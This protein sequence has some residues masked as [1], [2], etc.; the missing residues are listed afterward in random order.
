[1][2]KFISMALTTAMLAAVNSGY[3]ATK[4]GVFSQNARDVAVKEITR[5]LEEKGMEAGTFTGKDVSAG[6]IYDYDV[7]FFG[8]GWSGY[9]WL[10]LQGRMHLVEFV[11]KRGGGVI[12]SMFRCGVAARSSIRPIFPEIAWAYNKSNGPGIIIADKNHPIAQGL[13]EKFMTPFNDH[14][15]MRLGPDGEVVARDS[16]DDVAIACGQVGKGRVVFIGPWIGIDGDGKEI[17]PI[18][19]NDEKLLLNSIGWITAKS[20][21]EAGGDNVISEEVRLKVL[22]RE[23]TWDW[24]H[25]ERGFDSKPGILTAQMFEEQASL[26]DLL[27]RI[28]G[29]MPYAAGDLLKSSMKLEE[30]VAALTNRLDVVY[31]LSKREKKT[32]IN[33]MGAAELEKTPEWKGRFI[34]TNVVESCRKEAEELEQIIGPLKTKAAKARLE[35]ER[36]EDVSKVP[37]LI[38]QL[39][40]EDRPSRAEAALELG[41][42]GDRRAISALIAVLKDG[43]YPLRR[44]AIYALSWM[45]AKEAVPEL[46]KAGVDAK[47]T[48]TK[49][50]IVQALGMIGDEKAEDFLIGKLSDK[51][52]HILQNAILALGWLKSKKAIPTLIKKLEDENIT[53][54]ERACVVRALGHIGNESVI[55][56]L[57]SAAKKF[58]EKLP[59]TG[60]IAYYDYIPMQMLCELATGEIK[61][62]GKSEKGISQQDFLREKENFYWLTKKYNAFLGRLFH[63]GD[64][65]HSQ[66]SQI[67]R[68]AGYAGVT[69]FMGYTDGLFA[70]VFKGEA[71]AYEK[72]SAHLAKVEDYSPLFTE[73]HMKVLPEW[74]RN[75]TTINDK[76]SFE[77]DIMRRGNY[78]WLGGF[79]SEECLSWAHGKREGKGYM[80]DGEFREYLGRK[81]S[82]RELAGFG[83]NDIKAVKIPAMNDEGRKEKFLFA[84]YM[85]FV[86]DKGMDEYGETADWLK[87]MRMSTELLYNLGSRYVKGTSTYISAYPKLGYALGSYGPQSYSDH[88][89]ENNFNLEM[90][91][92]G[93]T[94]PVHGQFYTH[95]AY[96]NASVERGFA[97][98]FLHG[99]FFFEMTWMQIEKRPWGH[100]NAW[101]KGRF[102]A[103]E[104]Q[105]QKGRAISDYLMQAE[106]PKLIALLYSGRTTTLSYGKGS[107]DSLG[108]SSSSRKHRY[109]QNQQGIWETLVQSHLPVD[110]LWL[111]TLTKEKIGRYKVAIL[112]DAKSLAQ[113]EEQLLKDWVRDGGILISSG[114]ASLH[115]QWDI[116]LANYALADVFGAD[117]VKTEMRD[118]DEFWRFVERDVKPAKVDKIR[119]VDQEYEKYAQGKETAEYE[120]SIGYDVVKPTKGKTV[121]TWEDGS[122]AMVENRYGKGLS[123][124]ISP[125]Y[126]GLSYNTI[127]WTV[128]PCYLEFWDGARELIA[129]AVRRGLEFEHAGLPMEVGNCPHYVEAALRFQDEQGRA[130]VHLLNI[131]SKTNPVRGVEIKLHLPGK[132]V[133]NIYYP[134]SA[135][136]EAKWTIEGDAVRF[137]V[138][139]FDIHE[140]VVAEYTDKEANNK[141]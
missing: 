87:Q 20:S 46:L 117:Y 17:Y 115:N 32:E 123:V 109:T 54:E 140:I 31:E 29:L 84:E 137:N 135:R 107:P 35:K 113:T 75:T 110:I 10:N 65:T 111:E 40:R 134:Y 128:D 3:G 56:A 14:A 131:N 121:A 23:R 26:D 83:I 71:P 127:G 106:S 43:E 99:Q 60:T 97:S 94:R 57:Q 5:T 45:Q 76:A 58:H 44:N 79:W 25:D 91:L 50:R 49:R 37:E 118:K 68:Q 7:L 112:S 98:S 100:M 55:P 74:R 66:M 124:F 78:E 101:E 30:R 126:P 69:G 104:R 64:L 53:R 139:D 95:Q 116:S 59:T 36:Q 2:N 103:A 141:N 81:Y 6:K 120:Q 51:D 133:K 27:Y 19:S 39:S 12:F 18:P 11:Q 38:K 132:A 86:A 4:V 33:K 1:M 77:Y 48:P 125:I 89:S 105:F 108:D 96:G 24:T 62:G 93:E 8:G 129:S 15:V 85:E 90:H 80:N 61:T 119:L 114:T 130:L 52:Y 138:R 102:D 21:R 22:R 122:P 34:F 92:D 41:R 82:P 16:N 28:R 47:D 13:P 63:Y 136:A 72:Y 9:D 88:S 42:I 70:R 73:E 67:I